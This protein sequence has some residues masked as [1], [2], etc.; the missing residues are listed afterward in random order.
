MLFWVFASRRAPV[1]RY[2]TVF[3][4]TSL[5]LSLGAFL[6][7]CRVSLPIAFFLMPTRWWELMAGCMAYFA[8][9]RYSFSSHRLLVSIGFV[10]LLCIFFLPAKYEEC[11][12]IGSVLL[13][14]LLLLFVRQGE[15]VYRVLTSKPLIY[16]GLLSYSLYLWHWSVLF[17]SNWTVGISLPLVPL[18][19]GLILALAAAAYHFVELPLRRR[20][21][22]SSRFATVGIGLAGS[23]ALS[24]LLLVLSSP[25]S[26]KLYTGKPVVVVKAA[27]YESP[28]PVNGSIVIIGDSH[29]YEYCGV[30]R[31]VATRYERDLTCISNSA[32]I[33]PTISDAVP[34]NGVTLS[35]SLLKSKTMN[36][37]VDQTLGGGSGSNHRLIILSSFYT[38]YFAEHVGTLESQRLNNYDSHG[39]SINPEQALKL[40]LD[41]F[42]VFADQHPTDSI[43]V[44]LSTPVMPNLYLNEM[45]EPE[46]FRPTIS[47]K[48][49]VQIDR[50]TEMARLASVDSMIAARVSKHRNARVFQPFDVICPPTSTTCSSSIGGVRIYDD[51]HHLNSI[52]SEM[53]WSVLEKF[54]VESNILHRPAPKS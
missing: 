51:E 38:F 29:A 14:C 33:F 12:T 21:W 15:G 41:K 37:T 20:L 10:A 34:S 26:E 27:T 44:I 16:I 52:G 5:V 6:Y 42:D 54:L 46:W 24:I 35:K 53:V 47:S 4:I 8:V 18:Q 13:T 25:V 11:A 28:R 31:S 32:T 48:C 45:C 19:L 39:K 23:V 2:Y 50:A 40:W 17:L 3:M 36:D 1:R 9:K 7:Y 43:V 22:F 49:I 30:G